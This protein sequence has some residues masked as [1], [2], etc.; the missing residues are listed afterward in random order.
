MSNE[1][2]HTPEPWQVGNYSPAFVYDSKPDGPVEIA[3]CHEHT[4]KANARR[5]VACVNACEGCGTAWLEGVKFAGWLDEKAPDQVLIAA[6]FES[7]RLAAENKELIEILEAVQRLDYFQEH[8]GLANKVRA[9]LA[10][11]KAQS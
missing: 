2:K 10:K 9:I 3:K 11:V 7:G 1:A 5:I 4:G 8:S 6:L